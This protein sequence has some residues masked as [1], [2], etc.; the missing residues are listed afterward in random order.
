MTTNTIKEE[1]VGARNFSNIFVM[2]ILLIAGSGFFLAGLSS[3]LNINLLLISDTSEITFI[4]QGIALLF[5]GT[6]AIGISIYLILTIFWN[7]GS[8]YN[9]FSK[10][11]Q[12]VRIIRLG[13]PG[14]NRTV[15]LSYEFKNIKNLKFLIKQGLNPRCNI[16]L[17]LKDKREIPLFPA[18]FLLNPTEIENKAIQ[19]SNFLDVPLENLVI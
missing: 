17:V 4:P 3:Y 7:I 19:L 2:I 10:Q 15:F 18:Q 13:F 11:D 5:Y 6:G 12:L 8:G 9:E 16:L 1:I 14:K